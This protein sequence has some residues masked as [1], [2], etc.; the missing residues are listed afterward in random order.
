MG[1]NDIL[2]KDIDGTLERQRAEKDQRHHSGHGKAGGI[3]GLC[4]FGGYFKI[5]EGK[6]E[7]LIFTEH[8]NQ[9]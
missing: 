9:A 7:Y 1:Y 8:I 5:P 4:L 6:A 2:A 3:K